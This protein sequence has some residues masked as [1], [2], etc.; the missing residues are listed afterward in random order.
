MKHTTIRVPDSDIE[1]LDSLAYAERVDRAELIRRAIRLYLQS[2]ESD[3][4]TKR[5]QDRAVENRTQKDENTQQAQ[6]V[7]DVM[8][9]CPRC[10]REDVELTGYKRG[11]RVCSNCARK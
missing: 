4:T 8:R 1:S 5:T 11:M 2:V 3:T 9:T 6:R 10:K 7:S